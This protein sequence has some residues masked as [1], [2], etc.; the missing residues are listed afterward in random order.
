MNTNSETICRA[1][2]LTEQLGR[3]HQAADQELRYH[4]LQ[5]AERE[6]FALDDELERAIAIASD[7]MTRRRARVS[8]FLRYR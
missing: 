6:D 2:W 3:A 8:R 7:P 5:D 4:L 1:D